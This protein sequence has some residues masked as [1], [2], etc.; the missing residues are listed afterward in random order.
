MAYLNGTGRICLD[1]KSMEPLRGWAILIH[2]KTDP[3]LI[4]ATSDLAHQK[5][6]CDPNLHNCEVIPVTVTGEQVE[7]VAP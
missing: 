4:F 1:A 6:L 3:R 2:G 7:R 5:C